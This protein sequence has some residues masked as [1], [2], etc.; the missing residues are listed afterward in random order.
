MR[1]EIKKAKKQFEPI[2]FNIRIETLDELKTLRNIFATTSSYYDEI[3]KP[4]V[5]LLEDLVS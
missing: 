4:L 3:Y 1:N 5:K 2:Q